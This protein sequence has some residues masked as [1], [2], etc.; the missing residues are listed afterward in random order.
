[1][2]DLLLVPGLLALTVSA[3]VTGL[4][5][6]GGVLDFPE[7]RSLHS[8]PT[9]RSGGL[10]LLAGAGASGLFLV[11]SP[12]PASEMPVILAITLALGALG[13]ADDLFALGSKLKT[14][15]M[16]ALCVL[17]VLGV[18]PV[19][20]LGLTLDIVVEI[21]FWF[22]L[23]GSVLFVF[24]VVN[25]VNF[26]DGSDGM[27][28][29]VMIPSGIGLLLAGFVAGTLSASL[30]GLM[31]AAGLTGFVVLNWPPAR[32]FAGD[33]GSLAAGSLYALGAL[34]MAGE[35]FA[36]SLWLAPMFIMIFL[37]DVLFT[38]LRRALQGR[39]ALSAHSEHAYQ[40][41]IKAGWS[42][43][44]VAVLYGGLSS[45]IVLSGLAAAQASELAP[46]LSF[47][48]WTGFLGLGYL[49][50][51]AYCSKRGVRI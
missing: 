25:A 7:A 43:S 29:A 4:A 34:S 41:L 14:F 15:L 40:R 48:V 24:T 27:M 33:A 51:E 44:R 3:L 30:A 38:L 49:W 2:I 23:A 1:M 22:G 6:W 50:V 31:L 10:G 17:A 21:G 5:W 9:P 19:T 16:T 11:T 37:A 36:G 45:A 8:N 18:G 26:M 46:V 47:A 12:L 28:A 39:F 13:F 42:H 32:V 35:G 20:R